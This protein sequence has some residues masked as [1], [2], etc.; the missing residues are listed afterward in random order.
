MN[1]LIDLVGYT[2]GKFVNICNDYMLC[3]FC[4][5][6]KIMLTFNYQKSLNWQYQRLPVNPMVVFSSSSS[7]LVGTIA[8]RERTLDNRILFSQCSFEVPLNFK[9]DKPYSKVI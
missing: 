7:N 9:R 6:M 4:P 8:S 1:D 5:S 2:L 3:I